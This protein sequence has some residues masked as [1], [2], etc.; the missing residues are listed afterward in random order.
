MKFVWYCNHWLCKTT[1]ARECVC[2]CVCTVRVITIK[3]NAS[4]YVKN[5]QKYVDLIEILLLSEKK[6]N[7]FCLKQFWKTCTRTIDILYYVIYRLDQGNIFIFFLIY[8]FISY[9]FLMFKWLWK[10]F[11]FLLKINKLKFIRDHTDKKSIKSCSIVFN[12]VGLAQS[13]IRTVMKLKLV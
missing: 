11:F 9:L 7:S 6:N 3:D 10:F 13:H 5:K 8:P 2:V 12:C 1:H 4:V